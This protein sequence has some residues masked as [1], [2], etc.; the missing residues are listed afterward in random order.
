MGSSEAIAGVGENGPSKRLSGNVELRNEAGKPI[1][2]WVK[3]SYKLGH[4]RSGTR[5]MQELIE[6]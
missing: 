3:E 1:C 5:G 4:E 2:Y 6:K